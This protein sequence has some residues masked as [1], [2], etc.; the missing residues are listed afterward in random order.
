VTINFKPLKSRH[1]QQNRQ[2][3]SFHLILAASRGGLVWNIAFCVNRALK[4]APK[5]PNAV[6]A[7]RAV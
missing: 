5:L 2:A 6:S 1:P 7:A 3:T 4:L